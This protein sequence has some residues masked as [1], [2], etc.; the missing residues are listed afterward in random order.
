MERCKRQKRKTIRKKNKLRGWYHSLILMWMMLDGWSRAQEKTYAT[1]SICLKICSDLC[2]DEKKTN[3]H[4]ANEG[5]GRLSD[6]ACVLC[7]RL[8]I[9]CQLLSKPS[10][11]YIRLLRLTLLFFSSVFFFFFGNIVFGV[12]Q[13]TDLTNFYSSLVEFFF[14]LVFIVFNFV[15]VVQ[16]FFRRFLFLLFISDICL[17]SSI[18]LMLIT[19]YLSISSVMLEHCLLYIDSLWFGSYNFRWRENEAQ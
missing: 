3:T 19:A 7:W 15:C 18:V 2:A 12:V 6:F 10:C 9:F 11:A 16:F 5:N 4:R 17:R 13:P 14:G 8:Y 1:G